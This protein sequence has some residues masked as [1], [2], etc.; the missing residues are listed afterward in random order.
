MVAELAALAASQNLRSRAFDGCLKWL[1]DEASASPDGLS[2][3]VGGEIEP[4][5]RSCSLVFDHGSLSHPFLDTRLDLCI[6]DASG[7]S[8]GGL[9]LVGHYRLIT[10]LDGVAE[11]DYFVIDVPKP[12]GG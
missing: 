12:T 4:H 7:A 3:W 10:R 1:R 6:R 5:F 9:R 11:D 2:G 8:P